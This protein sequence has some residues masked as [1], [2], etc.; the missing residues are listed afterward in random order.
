MLSAP[1]NQ[2]RPGTDLAFQVWARWRKPR[3][4]FLNQGTGQMLLKCVVEVPSLYSGGL[5]GSVRATW[6]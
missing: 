6:S 4:E 2:S 3:L 5:E 1:E